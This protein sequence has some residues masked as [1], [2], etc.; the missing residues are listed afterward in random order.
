MPRRNNYRPDVVIT[1]I[2]AAVVLSGSLLGIMAGGAGASTALKETQAQKHLLVLADMPPGWTTE[3]GSSTGASGTGIPGGAALARCIGVPA[4]GINLDPLSV[5]SPYFES[6]SLEV[7]DTVD[8]F[9]SAKTASAT[10]AAVAN[11]KTPACLDTLMNGPLKRQLFT[12]GLPKGTTVGTVSVTPVKPADYG[13]DATG[14][15]VSIPIHSP[16]GTVTATITTIFFVRGSLGQLIN[17]NSYNRAFPVSLSKHL[18]TVAAG[19]I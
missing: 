13:A 19:R 15:T 5:D 3:K 6:K 16:G 7:Q 2:C 10:Q 4:R 18:T 11:T 8:A 12:D 17:F 14:F 1:S 9:L